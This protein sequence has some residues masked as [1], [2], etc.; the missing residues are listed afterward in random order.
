MTIPEIER[1]VDRM[2]ILYDTREQETAAL[3]KRLA[4]MPCNSERSK[5]DSGDYSCKT[6]LPNGS[7]Y[8]LADKFAIERKMSLGEICGNFCRGRERFRREFERFKSNGGQI[9]IIIENA[10]LGHLRAHK[11]NSQMSP[12]ALM[13]SLSAWYAEF[14]APFYLCDKD[15]SGYL[16]Y[17]LLKYQLREHL[18][19]DYRQEGKHD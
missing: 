3:R 11:Y 12:S 18:K 10:N 7:T 14:D 19:R 8:S 2:T 17:H 5:L 15:D 16:I 9:C 1:C 6:T 4:A 13:A